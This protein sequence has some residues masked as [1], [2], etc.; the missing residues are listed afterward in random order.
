MLTE[1]DRV[2]PVSDIVMTELETEDAVL[3]NLTTKQYFSLNPT[4]VH[5]WHLLGPDRTL[6]EV[7]TALVQRFD[8]APEQAGR[9]VIALVNQLYS[10]KLIERVDG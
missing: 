2:R 7:G 6:A 4:G 10:E 9:S 1:T 3:L 8:V 5:I